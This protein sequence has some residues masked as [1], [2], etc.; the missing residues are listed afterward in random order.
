MTAGIIIPVKSNILEYRETQHMHGNSTYI[1]L[2]T[3]DRQSVDIAGA[4]VL[5]HFRRV[6]DKTTPAKRVVVIR[7]YRGYTALA[8]GEFLANYN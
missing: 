1:S 6:N 8:N 4:H 3:I 7:Q 2:A 5:I